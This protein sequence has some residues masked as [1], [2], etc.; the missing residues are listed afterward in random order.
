M[1]LKWY[2]QIK[3]VDDFDIPCYLNNLAFLEKVPEL[4]KLFNCD[5]G[6]SIEKSLT[7]MLFDKVDLFAKMFSDAVEHE[8]LGFIQLMSPLVDDPW[9]RPPD[10][11]E[12]GEDKGHIRIIKNKKGKI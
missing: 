12:Y 1:Y 5:C 10:Y 8:N 2:L 3:D 9:R 4:I 11:E 6:R 7:K